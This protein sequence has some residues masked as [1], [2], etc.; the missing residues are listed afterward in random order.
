VVVKEGIL[1]YLRYGAMSKSL[2]KACLENLKLGY[3]PICRNHKIACFFA[4]EYTNTGLKKNQ[5]SLSVQK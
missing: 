1:N 4:L 2:P 5:S 3:K